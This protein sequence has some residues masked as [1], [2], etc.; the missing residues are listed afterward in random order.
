MTPA[1]VRVFLEYFDQ[2]K[3]VS[4]VLFWEQP[5]PVSPQFL[6]KKSR[7]AGTLADKECLYCSLYEEGNPTSATVPKSRSF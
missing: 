1:V 3:G 5:K 4:P 7:Q 6:L 2:L